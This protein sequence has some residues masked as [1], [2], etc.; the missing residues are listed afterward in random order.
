MNAIVQSYI[1]AISISQLLSQWVVSK[2]L[3]QMHFLLGLFLRWVK[4]AR[5]LRTWMSGRVLYQIGKIPLS[6]SPASLPPAFTSHRSENASR[7][8]IIDI[9]T[10][11]SKSVNFW[12]QM[13]Q[14]LLV[15]HYNDT[16]VPFF[17]RL[18]SERL[19]SLSKAF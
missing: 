17:H 12:L 6:F 2:G 15:G 13:F 19:L 16:N 7:A 8:N 11:V 14:S 3:Q 5:D 9:I 1:Y 4:K 10:E 18:L